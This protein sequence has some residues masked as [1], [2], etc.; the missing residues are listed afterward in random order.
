MKRIFLFL[1]ICL[2]YTKVYSIPENWENKIVFEEKGITYAVGV[3]RWTEVTR[4]SVYDAYL[5]AMKNYNIFHNTTMNTEYSESFEN[6]QLNERN[7]KLHKTSNNTIRRAII[8]RKKIEREPVSSLVRVK[9]L[10]QFTNRNERQEVFQPISLYV[11]LPYTLDRCLYTEKEI[12]TQF[13]TLNIGTHLF[14]MKNI[15]DTE[16]EYK[17]EISFNRFLKECQYKILLVDSEHY[18]P[19][20]YDEFHTPDGLH[21]DELVLSEGVPQEKY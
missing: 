11:P 7:E 3:S 16:G 4:R 6:G 1:I 12:D 13:G 18:G 19:Y 15:V 14:R 2:C 20:A 8:V 9:I 21:G 17:G 10:I 5:D